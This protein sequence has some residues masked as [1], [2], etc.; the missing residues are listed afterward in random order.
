LVSQALDRHPAIVLK[1]LGW[2]Y[3]R[4]DIDAEPGARTTKPTPESAAPP[5]AVG[6]KQS[7]LVEGDVRPFRGDYRAA[8]DA[9][10]RFADTLS[11]QPEVAEVRVVKMPL[12]INPS[13]TLSG[14]TTESLEQT[15][16]A[17]FKLL[18][19]LKS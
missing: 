8:I 2:K 14:N 7:G 16:K 4:T 18:L 13:L 10:N 11:Q 3:D 12:N 17:E 9:I 5:I 19:V 1:T 6:R 15:G